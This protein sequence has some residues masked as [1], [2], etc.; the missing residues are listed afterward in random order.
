MKQ[1]SFNID[2]KKKLKVVRQDRLSLYAQDCYLI[3]DLDKY[4]ISNVSTF[5]VAVVIESKDYASF[6]KNFDS[7]DGS[8]N[9]KIEFKGI[10]M[11]AISAKWARE[12]KTKIGD[13]DALIIGLETIGETINTASFTAVD[14]SLKTVQ[15]QTQYTEMLA[16]LPPLFKAFV[17]EMK[18][19]LE[20]LKN[21]V[22]ELEKNTPVDNWQ[23]AHQYR[24]S[25]VNTVS[26]YLGKVIPA[27]YSIIPVLL[28]GLTPEQ[29]KWANDFARTKIGDLVYGAPF[30]SRA[31]YKP[32]GYAGDYEMMNHLYRNEIV[33]KT[34]F[35]QCMHKY[36]IDEPAGAAVKNRGYYLFDKITECTKAYTGSAPFKAVSVASGPAMEMQLFIQK[37]YPKNFKME[38]TCLDQDEESLKH[39]QK[40]LMSLERSLNTGAAFKFNNM[41]IKNVIVGGLPEKEYD[42]IYS[43]GLF[44][45]FSEPVAVMAATKMAESLK[46]GGKLIIGNFSKNN[47]SVPFM[48]LVLDWHLIYRS[49]EELINMF[50]GIGSKIHVEKE[51]LG[52]NLFVVIEK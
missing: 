17:Y 16:T 3:S 25:I 51:P 30:A 20:E 26:V 14:I 33:G 15:D 41:A 35:D 44:D 5:G 43:A 34:L 7:A 10:F 24:E 40:Q 36:F 45:Y 6:K 19:W 22:N 29:M 8:C 4:E 46:P 28:Q 1:E 50:K 48:E 23:E 42:L 13:K 32:R 37:D 11:Q 18:D 31:Y 12:E 21:K 27:Q 47:P 2:Q 52:V 39:A 38:F 49:E 9:F